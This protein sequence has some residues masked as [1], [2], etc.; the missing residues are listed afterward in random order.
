MWQLGAALKNLYISGAA[1]ILKRRA[2]ARCLAAAMLLAVAPVPAYAVSV[3]MNSY[4]W[5][6]LYRY[7]TSGGAVSLIGPTDTLSTGFC[8]SAD[9]GPDGFLYGGDA[10]YIYRIDV[11]GPQAVWSKYLD[12][13]QQANDGLAISPSGTMYLSSN[14]GLAQSLW[15]ID[16]SGNTIPGSAVTVTK[17]GSEFHMGGMDFAP[18]GTL[19][20]TDSTKIYTVNLTTGAATYVA[21]R[22]DSSGGIFRDMDY[23]PDGLIRVLGSSGYLYTYNPATGAGGWTTGKLLYNGS[24]FSPSSLACPVPEPSIAAMLLAAALSGVA[25]FAMRRGS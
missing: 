19:Y 23:G 16:S 18:N 14:P 25:C 17:A 20:A 12:L 1:G 8:C 5:T 4:G 10:Y 13:S 11:S 24:S 9:F 21:T 2:L 3:Y 22:S 7:D 6:D 15:A